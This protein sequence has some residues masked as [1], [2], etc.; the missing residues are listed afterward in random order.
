MEN[1]GQSWVSSISKVFFFPVKNQQ[2]ITIRSPLV[3]CH[4]AVLSQLE[5]KKHCKQCHRDPFTICH[6][7]DK[8]H[9]AHILKRN[10]MSMCRYYTLNFLSAVVERKKGKK[11]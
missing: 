7:T 10:P 1:S 11:I 2:Q 5:V 3:L 4:Y 6:Q 9:P 8:A